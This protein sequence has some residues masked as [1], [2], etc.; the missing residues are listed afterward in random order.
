MDNCIEKQRGRR[1]ELTQL[2]TPL[3]KVTGFR[4]PSNAKCGEESE[5]SITG[6]PAK[7]PSSRSPYVRKHE[8]EREPARLKEKV[9]HVT[10]LGTITTN[11]ERKR[12][13]LGGTRITLQWNLGVGVVTFE[14]N[15]VCSR[16]IFGWIMM[17]VLRRWIR[18][19]M[20]CGTV[21]VLCG[22][23]LRPRCTSSNHLIN[24]S[25]QFVR[26]SLVLPIPTSIQIFN[27][28]YKDYTYSNRASVS[29]Y[30]LLESEN[31]M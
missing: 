20:N 24:T 13:D 6:K 17:V 10:F 3:T 15:F 22:V 28:T 7:I 1:T 5:P 31:W 29:I 18:R 14:Y 27:L 11:I 23:T 4:T 25:P 12:Q 26:Y 30:I 21:K 19:V 16:R 2:H 9:C 8:R